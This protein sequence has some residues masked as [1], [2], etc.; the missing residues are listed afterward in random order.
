MSTPTI[1]I[2][3][4]EQFL[5]EAIAMDFKRRKFNVLLAANGREAFDIVLKE[6]VDIVL[7]DI[8]MPN[9][10]GLELLDRIKARDAN[11]PVVMFITGFADL[12]VEDAYARGADAIFPKP[13][14]RKA[15]AA[16]V[17]RAIT[18]SAERYSRKESRVD[19]DL[20]I[21]IKFRS[22]D[23]TFRARVKNLGRGGM[24]VE[25]EGGFPEATDE[26]DF[27]LDLPSGPNVKVSGVGIVRW[28]R[29]LPSGDQ[30]AGCGIEFTGLDR[31]CLVQ[32]IE[33]INDSKVKA[34]IPKS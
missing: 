12:T 2:V 11:L 15:L 9:G 18:D 7:S 1:L 23:G 8:R 17:D 20:G 16:A 22:T 31:E 25:M 10:D 29:K 19:S 27:R 28:V 33:L 30:P 26:A 32:V 24:F 6:K 21:G 34:F 5:R 3:D 4:D 14:D 13:F